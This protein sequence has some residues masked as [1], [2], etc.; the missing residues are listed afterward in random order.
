MCPP[1]KQVR[2]RAK[3]E[4]KKEGKAESKFDRRTKGWSAKKKKRKD[5]LIS[6]KCLLAKSSVREKIIRA[7][8]DAGRGTRR[9]GQAK[10]TVRGKK[11][12]QPKATT[13]TPHTN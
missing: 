7:A 9:P 2:S 3:G 6:Y 5:A 1:K 11:I 13:K 10:T 8:G 12:S 4:K